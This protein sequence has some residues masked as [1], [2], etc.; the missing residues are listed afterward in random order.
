MWGTLK[1]FQVNSS[2]Y[3]PV[4]S[5][6][7]IQ[8][9]YDIILKYVNLDS[10]VFIVFWKRLGCTQSD[11]EWFFYTTQAIQVTDQRK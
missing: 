5:G 6:Q 7:L 9:G 2:V 11:I 3:Q 8:L 4:Y 1:Y 10:I